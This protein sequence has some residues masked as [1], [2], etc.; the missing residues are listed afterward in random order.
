[1]AHYIPFANEGNLSPYVLSTRNQLANT[2]GDDTEENVWEPM[3]NDPEGRRER[4]TREVAL[5][6]AYDGSRGQVSR[7]AARGT[8]HYPIA[9]GDR[10]PV[11]LVNTE[12][13]RGERFMG[14]LNVMAMRRS[15]INREDPRY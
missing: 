4:S 10:V 3:K 1:M 7:L 6:F 11:P 8:G 13:P 9:S 15:V 5:R 12:G 14:G 2:V